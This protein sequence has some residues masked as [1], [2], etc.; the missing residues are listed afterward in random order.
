[1]AVQFGT[2]LLMYSRGFGAFMSKRASAHSFIAGQLLFFIVS[3]VV[4][5]GGLV[6]LVT[7]A[8]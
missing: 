2:L 4:L 5:A 8:K 6:R 1:V 3:L 7:T